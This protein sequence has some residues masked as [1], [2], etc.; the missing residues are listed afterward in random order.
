MTKKT[1]SNPSEQTAKKLHQLSKINPDRRKILRAIV[2]A[3]PENISR[4]AQLNSYFSSDQNVPA[5]SKT[6][7]FSGARAFAGVAV[8]AILVIGSSTLMWIG[9]SRSGNNN[10]QFSQ[11]QLQANGKLSNALNSI[12]QQTT[13]ETTAVKTLQDESSGVNAAEQQLDK[14]QESVDVQF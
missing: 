8:V 7:L 3:A 5:T 14:M 10:T 1:T 2:N 11:S 12:N 6:N 9:F 13:E 4:K